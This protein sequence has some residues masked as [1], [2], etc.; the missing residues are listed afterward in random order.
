MNQD[1]IRPDLSSI[2]SDELRELAIRAQVEDA[3]ALVEFYR[4]ATVMVESEA[5]KRAVR[6]DLAETAMIWVLASIARNEPADTIERF[7]FAQIDGMYADSFDAEKTLNAVEREQLAVASRAVFDALGPRVGPII[8]DSCER[9]SALPDT[10]GLR[11]LATQ[12]ED[13]RRSVLEFAPRQLLFQTTTV[14]F[15]YSVLR[16]AMNQ[17]ANVNWELM[18]GMLEIHAVLAEINCSIAKKIKSGKLTV[19]DGKVVKPDNH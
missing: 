12:L 18:Q 13:M 5:F 15:K 14:C 11:I 9:L 7:F 10:A 2:Q 17:G 16:K 6:L 1:P 4:F 19:V 8:Q 3:K